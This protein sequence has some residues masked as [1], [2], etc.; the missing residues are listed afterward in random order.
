MK[1]EWKVGDRVEIREYGCIQYVDTVKEITKG[2][3]I[4]ITNGN[5]LFNPDGSLRGGGAWC[6]YMRKIT[7][8]EYENYLF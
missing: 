1:T 5:R 3:N 4:R 6:I 8:Q 7:E 2:G